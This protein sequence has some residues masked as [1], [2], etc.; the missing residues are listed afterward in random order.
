MTKE[1]RQLAAALVLTVSQDGVSFVTVPFHKI[2]DELNRFQQQEN[3]D[4]R[5][6]QVCIG[7]VLMAFKA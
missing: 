4:M 3:A 1:E 7:C 2:Y 5:Y 6:K